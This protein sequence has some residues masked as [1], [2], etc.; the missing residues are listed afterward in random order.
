MDI[1]F[2]VDTSISVFPEEWIQLRHFIQDIIRFLQIGPK[3]SQVGFVSYSHIAQLSAPLNKYTTQ[4]DAIAGA[5]NDIVH[6]NASTKTDK[7][8]FRA[9]EGCFGAPEDRPGFEN[10]CIVMTDGR[11]HT[12]VTAA[13][14]KLRE[15]AS[16]LAIGIDGADETQLQQM[17]GYDDSSWLKVPS[18]KDLE[19]KVGTVRK[20]ICGGTSFLLFNSLKIIL[21]TVKHFSHLQNTRLP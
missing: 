14:A 1:C 16:I 2:V 10:L 13:S 6:L 9:A 12:P 11:S 7:G 15:V 4:A 21:I 8:L 5:W 18:F 20:H 19:Q 3:K 17:V